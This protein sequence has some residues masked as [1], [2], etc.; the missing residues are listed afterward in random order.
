MDEERFT[1]RPPRPD[2]GSQRT[3]QDY[4]EP[5]WE[6]LLTKATKAMVIVFLAGLAMYAIAFFPLWM[7]MFNDWPDWVGLTAAWMTEKAGWMMWAGAAY[8]VTL[9]FVMVTIWALG[10]FDKEPH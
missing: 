2:E 8:E 4:I 1:R 5:W 7:S 10:Y 6:R 9:V 3:Q